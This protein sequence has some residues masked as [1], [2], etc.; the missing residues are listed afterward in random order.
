MVPEVVTQGD[1]HPVEDVCRYA[2]ENW[3]S[4]APN[5]NEGAL[6]QREWA[7]EESCG[8][9]SYGWDV[10]TTKEAQKN[11]LRQNGLSCVTHADIEYQTWELKQDISL[12]APL[13]LCLMPQELKGKMQQGKENEWV[14]RGHE[15]IS[16]PLTAPNSLKFKTFSTS[17]GMLEIASYLNI[18]KGTPSDPW[19]AMVNESC[20]LHVHV[21]RS[22][23]KG[24]KD[25]EMIPLPVLQ[26]V[27]LIIVR[28]EDLMTCLHPV[29]RRNNV[30]LGSNLMGV[31]RCPHSCQRLG[32]INLDTAQKKIFAK[33]MTPKRLAYLMDTAYNNWPG[34]R[35]NDLRYKNVNF[36]RLSMNVAKTIEFRQY[37]GTLDIDHIAHWVHFIVSVVRA[38]E[39][40]ATTDD[41]VLSLQTPTTAAS[42]GQPK[43]TFPR[44][45]GD[46]Y[47]TRC[48]KVTDELE[49]L[50]DL[51]DFEEE[52]RI[53][54]RKRFCELNPDGVTSVT[55][56]QCPA[57]RQEA[58]EKE[59]NSRYEPGE[60]R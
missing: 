1:D 5:W 27:A 33:N 50:Y 22:R 20:G 9:A 37:E 55:E 3:H 49:N 28:Y 8:P 44:Q 24:E 4:E 46:K 53:W 36:Q 60:W 25:S 45:Q 10:E 43:V 19:G 11:V 58:Q 7:E 59:V 21:A 12:C 15:L 34:R 40:M 26:H 57:C 32:G 17:P 48:A 56:E 54:W 16:P 14:L 23:P 29:S 41:P 35:S 52:T 51:L 6:P 42:Q 30:M 31:R 38:A 18:V 39:R 47:K 13:D 2:G